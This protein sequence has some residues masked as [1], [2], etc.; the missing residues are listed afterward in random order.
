MQMQLVFLDD[1]PLRP[2]REAPAR[3]IWR[4]TVDIAGPP[5][6]RLGVLR[7]WNP[8]APLL[9]WVVYRA[10]PDERDTG[11]R[12]IIRWSYQGAYGGCLIVALYPVV[13]KTRTLVDA[14]R[15]AADPEALVI[16]RDLAASTA[17]RV[18]GDCVAAT[19]RTSEISP[20]SA[21]SATE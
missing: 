20:N 16:Q 9:G 5:P 3:P 2:R 17:G 19:S 10:V 7:L 11:L 14:L 4:E 1:L 13:A 12:R 8:H 6:L 15:D 21:G 18:T